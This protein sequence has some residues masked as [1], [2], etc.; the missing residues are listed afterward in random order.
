MVPIKRRSFL[1]GIAAAIFGGGAALKAKKRPED[2]L[3]TESEVDAARDAKM[4]KVSKDIYG[5]PDMLEI[6]PAD[7]KYLDVDEMECFQC[8]Q[9]IPIPK[10]FYVPG[11]MIECGC[12]NRARFV[13]FAKV[14]TGD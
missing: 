8:H 14:K 4:C 9:M 5:T 6:R 12:G 13:F 1:Q 11:D 10:G 2:W 3:R 7:G